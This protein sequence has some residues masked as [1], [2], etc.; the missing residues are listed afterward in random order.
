MDGS[1]N[2]S[3]NEELIK[4]SKWLATTAQISYHGSYWQL[5]LHQQ[6]IV[7]MCT[8]SLYKVGIIGKLSKEENNIDKIYYEHINLHEKNPKW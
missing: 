4:S 8:I 5:D 2:K 6:G 7:G 1:W 3:I